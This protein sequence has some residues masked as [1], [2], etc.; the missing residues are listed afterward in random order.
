MRLDNFLT[1]L[2]PEQ[3]RS[4]I[5]R[6]IKDGRVT[7]PVA[8]LRA[9]TVVHAGQVFVVEIPAPTE[10]TPEPEALPLRII[11]QDEDLVVLD[12]P[13]GMVVHP[14][15]GHSRRNAGQRAA[16][17]R[18][19]SERH[20]R[21]A[22]A[23]DRASPGSRHVRSDGRG[24]ERSRAPGAVAP[25]HRSRG[26]QGIHRAGVGS[27]AGRQAHRRADRARSVAAAEDVDAGAARPERRDAGDVRAPLQGRV[28]AE[29][30]DRHR[31]HAPDPRPPERHRPSHRRRSDLRRGPPADVGDL[32]AVQRLER[33]FLHS[34]RLAFTHPRD[35]RRV[36][37]DSP[38]PL[39]LQAVIDDIEERESKDDEP[40][41]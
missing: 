40:D 39:D 3:S 6:L 9:S 17:P 41:E 31:T 37:F 19:G 29:S 25:V 18:Q 28:A 11:Y 34:A 35:G 7:G 8:T 16:A 20:R 10:P 32:R 1:A 15:A 22:A 27:G 5:Q 12:K 2:L 36:E 38:L 14:G 26:G 21:R 33:P 30:G 13:A 23:R 24:Q 4:H